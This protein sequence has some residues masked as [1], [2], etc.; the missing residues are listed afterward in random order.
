MITTRT[1]SPRLTGSTTASINTTPTSV[2]QTTLGK[3]GA[4]RPGGAGGA[5][6]GVP[7]ERGKTAAQKQRVCVQEKLKVSLL[8]NIFEVN[9]ME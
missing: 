2:K 9:E 3:S 4:S 5:G 8:C 1:T 7:T 6:N